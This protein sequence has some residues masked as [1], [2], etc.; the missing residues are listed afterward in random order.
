MI[1]DWSKWRRSPPPPSSAERSVGDIIYA[2]DE[3]GA[4]VWR[5]RPSPAAAAHALVLGAS[6]CG[7]SVREASYLARA[8]IWDYL[9]LP[10]HQRMCLTVVDAK[11]DLVELLLQALCSEAPPHLVPEIL[12]HTSVVDPF[13]R[14]PS[15]MVPLN[16][17]H[18]S[19]GDQPPGVTALMLSAII[20]SASTASSSTQKVQMGGRQTE[21]LTMAIL[22]C[23]TTGLRE[24]SLLWALDAIQSGNLAALG[25]RST[26][27]RASAYLCTVE[28]SPELLASTA[29]RLRMLA[30]YEELETSI[31]T[32]G[33]CISADALTQPGQITLIELGRA[34]LPGLAE[35][36]GSTLV[37][38][39]GEHLLARPNATVAQL[40]PSLLVV[41]EAQVVAGAIEDIGVR[42]L[43]VGRSKSIAATVLSQSTLILQNRAPELM[44]AFSTNAAARSIARMSV[45]D[46]EQWV[47]GV[48]PQPGGSE[49]LGA[50]RSRLLSQVATLPNREFFYLD[51]SAN[52][53]TRARSLEVDLDAWRAAADQHSAD[54]AAARRRWTPSGGLPNRVTLAEYLQSQ[55]PAQ[56]APTTRPR[57]RSKWG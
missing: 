12:G 36:F 22:A 29:A 7:K 57:P 50:I 17:V 31:G 53:R 54:I 40:H 51:A 32:P 16:F 33:L 18:A 41:D 34:P 30:I 23:L 24:A 38:Q 28:P 35:I 11:G 45:P 21:L 37:R 2:L 19:W 46:C 14:D 9:N 42:M 5:S 39:V 48:A 6:G 20:G 56:S 3:H 55:R 25:R 8:I 49:S 52:I 27:Q 4:P 1:V 43:A 13:S 26:S 15:A 47:R 44:A 10:P